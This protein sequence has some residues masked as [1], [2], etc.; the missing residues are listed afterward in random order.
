MKKTIVILML[1]FAALGI[2]AQIRTTKIEKLHLP[3]SI[4]AYQVKFF[5][6]G[7]ILYF[8]NSSYDGI[9]TI[10]QKGEVKTVTTDPFSGF[11]YDINEDNSKIVYRRSIPESGLRTQEIVEKNLITGNSMTLEKGSSIS[12]PV[13]YS[14]RAVYTKNRAALN[15]NNSANETKVLGIEDTKIILLVNGKKEVFDPL[16]GG[17]Y[18]WPTLSPDGKMIAAY[19]MSK[20]TFVATLDGKIISMLGRKNSPT[21]TRDGKWIVYMNDKDNGHEIIN[22]DIYAVSIDGKQTVRLTDAADMIEL[23]PACSPSENKIA[24]TTLK[25]ELFILSYE[26][27]R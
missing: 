16:P 20:G 17:S 19:E 22:S 15:I 7:G 10:S 1:V 21:F 25:G 12:I 14:G 18:I 23:N 2:D 26:E 5:G 27:S 6:P 8:S 11:S 3:E 24:F 9:W 13:Y 4:S